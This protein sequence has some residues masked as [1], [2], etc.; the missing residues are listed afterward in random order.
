[1]APLSIT[2]GQLTIASDVDSAASFVAQAGTAG[3]YVD[4]F[5]IGARRGVWSYTA[6][7]AFDSLERW[8]AW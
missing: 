8:R 5:A 1:M 4:A 2:S 3:S 7:G 6:N